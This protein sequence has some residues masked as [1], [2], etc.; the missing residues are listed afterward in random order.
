VARELGVTAAPLAQWRE[1][2][3]AEGQAALKSRPANERDEEIH[4]LRA[5]VGEITMHNELLLDR[6]HRLE[7][8]LPVASR[9][10][11]E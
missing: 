3:L 11:G 10:R 8:G 5:K 7:G 6:C 2:F 4:R 9:W 1:Q